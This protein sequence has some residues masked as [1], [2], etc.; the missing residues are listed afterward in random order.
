MLKPILLSIVFVFFTVITASNFA[1]AIGKIGLVGKDVRISLKW[2]S[3]D[4]KKGERFAIGPG[5]YGRKLK[6]GG[7]ERFYELHVPPGYKS[8][9]PAP[10]VLVFHGGGSYPAAIRYESQM[11]RTADQGGFIVVYPAGTNKR[12]LIKDRWLTWND[13]RPYKDGSPNKVDDAGFVSA[14]LDDLAKLFNIDPKQVYA[15]G[16][17]NGAQFSY[18]LSKQLSDRIAAIA[19]VAGHRSADAQF[20][21]PPRPISVMQFAGLK[22]TIGPY[23]GGAPSFNAAFE[24]KLQP[25]EKTIQS[26][27]DFNGCPSKPIEVKKIGR[28][29][30]KRFGPGREGVEVILWTLED[31]GHT[32]PGGKSLPASDR[33]GLGA[34]NQDINASDLMWEFFKK[35]PLK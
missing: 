5:D 13:G 20:P 7:R 16:F 33:M 6:F 22:D 4:D 29:I 11:D 9:E 27:V 18:R 26:W 8:T 10:V 35:H 23:H 21:P 32:W 24:T 34:I 30:Q 14:L 28:A 31:G 12:W 25:V 3:E 1:Y 19:V 17:S 2:I 15:A